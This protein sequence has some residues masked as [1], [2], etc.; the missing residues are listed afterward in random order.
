[1]RLGQ[2]IAVIGMAA[3]REINIKLWRNEPCLCSSRS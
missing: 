2:E 1:M 3:M